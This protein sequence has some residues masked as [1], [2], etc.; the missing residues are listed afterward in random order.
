MISET[1]KYNSTF[2]VNGAYLSNKSDLHRHTEYIALAKHNS[3]LYTVETEDDIATDVIS[4][5]NVGDFLLEP[6]K[7]NTNDSLLF[8][9]SKYYYYTTIDPLIARAVIS[10]CNLFDIKI[11]FKNNY[12]E[13]ILLPAKT[14]YNIPYLGDNDILLVRHQCVYTYKVMDVINNYF[15]NTITKPV[16]YY[17]ES[18]SHSMV[19][20]EAPF[21]NNGSESYNINTIKNIKHAMECMKLCPDTDTRISVYIGVNDCDILGTMLEITLNE[22]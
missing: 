8:A 6:C 14:A 17:H 1:K 4:A 2:G 10:S 13:Y 12:R 9:D 22:K 3:L 5:S 21:I 18:T 15:K 16:I 11:D 7:R 19:I 20:V